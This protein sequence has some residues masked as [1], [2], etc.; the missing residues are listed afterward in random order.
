MK[1][2]ACYLIWEISC[3]AFNDFELSGSCV[4]CGRLFDFCC[5]VIGF[6]WFETEC[7]I[8]M[9]FDPN[10]NPNIFV[11]RKW[12]ERIS[13]H[14]CMKFLRRTN[15][16]IYSYQNFDTNEYPNKYLD[17]K[18]SNIRIYSLYS[19]QDWHQFCTFTI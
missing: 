18:Y 5:L 9:D 7:D 17:R 4:W 1:K 19:G 3:I 15:I 13:E 2:L 14:T 11:S 10:E 8:H 6:C 12:H 16:R